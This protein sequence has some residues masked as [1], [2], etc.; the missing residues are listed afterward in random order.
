MEKFTIIEKL[1]CFPQGKYRILFEEDQFSFWNKKGERVL[2]VFYQSIAEILSTK[3]EIQLLLENGIIHYLS[4]NTG[5]IYS[6]VMDEDELREYLR[7]RM[8]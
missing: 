4:L 1:E 7:I 2:Y 6:T 3:N 8:N 5:K